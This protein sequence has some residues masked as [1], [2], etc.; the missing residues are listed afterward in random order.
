MTHELSTFQSGAKGLRHGVRPA[1][2]WCVRD[3]GRI[4]RVALGIFHSEYT[5]M[6][7]QSVYITDWFLRSYS[8]RYRSV[9]GIGTW[10]LHG[11]TL[12]FVNGRIR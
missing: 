5:D 1:Y 11:V 3:A 7:G 12:S 10:P 9:A 2:S 4:V 8:H 6:M